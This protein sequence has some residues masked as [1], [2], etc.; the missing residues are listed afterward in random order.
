MKKYF[1]K[2]VITQKEKEVHLSLVSHI[3]AKDY[4]PSSCCPFAPQEE[5]TEYQLT[6][7]SH[8]AG[9]RVPNANLIY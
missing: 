3:T 4:R 2:V 7:A 1:Q 6:L 8:N 5:S 9:G